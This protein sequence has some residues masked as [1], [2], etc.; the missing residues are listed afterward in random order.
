MR[1]FLGPKYYPHKKTLSTPRFMLRW[2]KS[3]EVKKDEEVKSK[4][5]REELAS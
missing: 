2:E 3:E 5:A 1:L 4:E